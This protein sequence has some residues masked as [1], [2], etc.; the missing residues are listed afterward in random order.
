MRD[1]WVKHITLLALFLIDCLCNVSS[2]RFL[3][4]RE[5]KNSPLLHEKEVVAV[6]TQTR[7]VTDS[8][9][10]SLRFPFWISFSSLVVFLFLFSWTRLEVVVL[11]TEKSKAKIEW[12][13]VNWTEMCD[14]FK[15]IKS[16]AK[17]R[18]PFVSE[19]GISATGRETIDTTSLLHVSC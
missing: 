17:E 10:K 11:L 15:S 9:T 8:G 14:S 3:P 19:S 1:Q 16:Q 6:A 4:N 7:G 2:V 12:R 13:K 18:N 5:E